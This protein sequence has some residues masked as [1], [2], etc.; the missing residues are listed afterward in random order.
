M[1]S[2]ERGLYGVVMEGYWRD[3]GN[4]DEYQRV[5]VDFFANAVDLD[6]K[7]QKQKIGDAIL[8]TGANAKLGQDVM[9]SGCVTLGDDVSVGE[10]ALLH[11]CIVGDRTTVGPGCRIE[12]S[13]LWADNSVGRETTMTGAVVCNKSRLGR[14]VQLLDKV[15]VS[16]ECFIGDSATIK[17]NCKVWP[18]K[19][20]DDGAT[21]S[22]SVVWGEKWNREL[23]TDAKVTGLALTEM[24]P[25]MAVKVGA[26]FGAFLGRGVSV[27]TSR[28]A[29]DTSRLLKR[30][31]LS[32][33]L[34]AG[35][36]VAD[37][38]TLP[39]PVMRYCLQKGK[40]AAG[41]YLRHNPLDYRRFDIIF[42]DGNGLDMP[43]SKL[44]KVERLYYGEDFER[45]GLDQI[46]QLTMPQATLEEYR[47]DFM[48][49]IR[50]DVIKRAG[51][52]LVVD[53]SNGSSSQIFPTLFSE[54]GISAVELNASLNPRKFSISPEENAK[55]IVQLSAIV[56]SLHADVGFILNPAA[57]K[58]LAVDENGRPIDSQLLLLVVTDLFLQLHK[59]RRIAVP[60]G[61][62]M[63]VE[64]IAAERNVEIIRVPDDHLSMMEV[65][66]RGDVDFVGGTRGG[67]MFPGFHMGSDAIVSVVKILEMLAMTKSRF[68]E[69]RERH[70]SLKRRSVS[71]P[72]P[73]SRKGAVMRK[74][75][76][77]SKDKQR[78]LID[79]VRILEDAGWALVAPDRQKASFNITAESKSEEAL[80]DL[81]SRYKTMVEQFQTN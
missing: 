44:K 9:I 48:T 72:C 66:M 37:L 55:A 28:D 32:G 75:I 51:F 19:I 5:H 31:L 81:V 80:I 45:A 56:T 43:T 63:G 47:A 10:G 38:E 58:L 29:S 76:T 53:H 40:Y 70:E 79:G 71:V 64:E 2:K 1:L 6:L 62:S 78:Q 42:F 24:S 54:L 25:E 21:V 34:A 36:D 65:F 77:E 39:A 3:V 50:G 26:A 61:A 74:L 73:W 12:N 16:D 60:V 15:I 49:G 7:Y 17:A 13:V 41:I 14:R 11:N 18:N 20:V 23:F 46:G 67:F 69:L 27:V 35:V 33:L 8:Y 57:E 59:A 4:I 52:K 30:G 22:S 68:G